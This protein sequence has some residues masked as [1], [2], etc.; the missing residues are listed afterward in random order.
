MNTASKQLL[1]YVSGLGPQLAQNIIDYRNENGPFKSRQQLKKIPRLGAKAFEQATGFLRIRDAV[2]P[3]DSSAI[4]PE[5]YHVVNA[6]VADIGD[7]VADL[8]KNMSLRMKIRLHNYVSNTV[9][10]SPILFPLLDL[11]DDRVEPL[12]EVCKWTGDW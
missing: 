7:S 9:G 8:M 2:N 5:S 1:T 3:L 6:M 4:H 10:H 12:L 11:P